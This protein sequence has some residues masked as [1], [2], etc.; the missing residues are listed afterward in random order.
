MLDQMRKDAEE[1]NAKREE[2]L[3]ENEHKRQKVHAEMQVEIERQR[4]ATETNRL[5]VHTE[6]LERREA[7]YIARKEREKQ[8]LLGLKENEKLEMKA[9]YE[10]Q[11]V[12]Q[13]KLFCFNLQRNLPPIILTAL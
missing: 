10:Q 9:C 2:Q 3:F 7:E 8:E 1:A 11:I 6:M 12:L 13:R 5:M 4:A